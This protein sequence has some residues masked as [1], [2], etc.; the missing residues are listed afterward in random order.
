MAEGKGFFGRFRGGKPAADE[1]APQP[2]DAPAP[3]GACAGTPAPRQSWF[4]KLKSGLVPLLQRAVENRSPSVFTKRKL[5]AEALEE[6]EDMLIH[7]DLGAD[8]AAKITDALRAGRYDKEISDAEVKAVLAEEI[9]QG[10]RAGR[11]A[12]R[13]RPGAEAACHPG[14]RRQRHRQDHHH[15]QAR[16]Q[17]PRRGQV[18]SCSPPATRSAPRP[19]SS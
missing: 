19:S 9:A 13:H 14:R 6:L 10:A 12:A 11:Q 3:D 18:A 7:A 5:D 17:A 2:P 8:T 15:R 16:R 4:Q 1:T